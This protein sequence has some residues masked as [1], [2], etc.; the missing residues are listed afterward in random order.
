[1]ADERERAI[2]IATVAL[3]RAMAGDMEEA[4]NYVKRL[5]GTDGLVLAIKAWVDTF[6]GRVVG[7]PEEGRT[8]AFQMRLLNV[9]TGDVE[10]ADEAPRHAAWA[11]RLIAARLADD[12]A[13][14]IALLKAPAEG[15]QLGDAIMGL[16]HSVAVSLK[17]PERL[18]AAAAEM[19]HG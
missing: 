8:P 12:E 4:A 9:D 2:K 5:N 1:M 19:D 17:D 7:W 10:I 11:G 14:F 16:L 18:R 13:G 3:H 6:I 15:A